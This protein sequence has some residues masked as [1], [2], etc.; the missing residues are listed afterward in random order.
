MIHIFKSVDNCQLASQSRSKHTNSHTPLIYTG[1]L[2]FQ[3]NE[4]S[5]DAER[6]SLIAERVTFRNGY[7]VHFKV[8]SINYHRCDVTSS[9]QRDDTRPPMQWQ[10]GSGQM[11]NAGGAGGGGSNVHFADLPFVR[12][13]ALLL[14]YQLLLQ[15]QV[16]LQPGER[17]LLKHVQ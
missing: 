15:P 8:H 6:G 4:R 5:R 2:T 3:C 9:R 13:A 14:L 11:L 7:F 10:R 12:E 16:R 1:D 17:K